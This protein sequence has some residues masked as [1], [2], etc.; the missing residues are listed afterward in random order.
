MDLTDFVGFSSVV[1]D[2]FGGGGLSGVNVGHDTDV[3]VVFEPDFAVGGGGGGIEVDV[4]EL[5]AAECVED[6]EGLSGVASQEGIT[7]L[8]VLW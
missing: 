4:L 6:D 3:A 5:G 7:T 8:N 2:A 1:E